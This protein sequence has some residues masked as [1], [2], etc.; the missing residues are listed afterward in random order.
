MKDI[1]NKIA[2]YIHNTPVLQ[3]SSLDDLFGCKLFFKCENFQK[4]GS[5]K[6]RG[7]SHAILC[8][9]EKERKKGVVTHSSG[10]FAQALSKAAAIQGI[11]AYIVMPNNA[12]Q[13][14]VDAVQDFGAEIIR[15]EPTVEAREKTAKILE[16]KTGATF[17]HPSNQISVIQGQ[18]TAA[19]ELLAA[20]PEIEVIFCPVGGGG[21]IAG[22]ALAAKNH[23]QPVKVYGG[24][25]EEA[26]DASRSLQ[27]GKIESNKTT[28][29][30]ADG[31]RTQLGEHNFPIIKEY[32][33]D[34][35]TVREEEIVQAMR[36]IW[37]RLKIIIEPSCAVP[38]AALWQSRNKFKEKKVGII[39]SGGNVDLDKLPF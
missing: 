20:F 21:L 12:P 18:G 16:E 37:E 36:L 33:E 34:I 32:V 24:E 14:K 31:L 1:A 27:S 38:V 6:I 7:A 13:V 11:P 26:D 9:T 2:P 4:T 28:N 17:I 15:C 3:S 10:N 23:T 30:V 39:L 5:F 19:Y 35:I 8:L 25:P 22:T 29:T